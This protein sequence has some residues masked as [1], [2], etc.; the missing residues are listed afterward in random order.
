MVLKKATNNKVIYIQV[1]WC[2]RSN[3]GDE[4]KREI[5]LLDRSRNKVIVPTMP[6]VLP[7]N[8][9]DSDTLTN[10]TLREVF[11]FLFLF[12]LEYLLVVLVLYCI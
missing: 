8:R 10:D 12:T 5:R 6:D 7:L 9:K 3:Y 2:Q 1:E 11:K 4:K